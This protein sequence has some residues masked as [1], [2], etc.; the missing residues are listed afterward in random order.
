MLTRAR[1]RVSGILRRLSGNPKV[2]S[3][4]DE[5]REFLKKFCENDQIVITSGTLPSG[6]Y[7]PAAPVGKRWIVDGNTLV[8]N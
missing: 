4:K 8:L 3:L 7:I 2:I 5:D 1:E 6:E